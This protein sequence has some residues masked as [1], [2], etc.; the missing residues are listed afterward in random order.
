M[1]ED[2]RDWIIESRFKAEQIESKQ[3][4]FMPETIFR[5]RQHTLEIT[6][7]GLR[8]RKRIANGVIRVNVPLSEDLHTEDVQ[9]YIRDA[10]IETYR[11]EAKELLPQRV[12]ELS[13]QFGFD[14]R[15]VHI[16][17]TRSQ[18]GSC[19]FNNDISLSLHLVRLPDA[20]IDYVLLHELVHTEIKNHSQSFWR[21][22]DQVT[23][24]NAR[25][26]DRLIRKWK[27]DRI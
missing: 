6:R 25:R 8:R 15:D 27:I 23:Y 7:D 3:T 22:L 19:S 26:L 18:W 10:V 11:R 14:Y 16:R 17:D 2:H 20:L 21:R 13:F 4:V 9:S 24:G 12:F 1:I 5:T